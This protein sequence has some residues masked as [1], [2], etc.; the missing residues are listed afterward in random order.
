M[1]IT[2]DAA[3]NTQPSVGHPSS[4]EQNL[5]KRTSQSSL[6]NATSAGQNLNMDTCEPPCS[7]SDQNLTMD[8]SASC[9]SNSE[10]CLNNGANEMDENKPNYISNQHQ[11]I[12]KEV[13]TMDTNIPPSTTHFDKELGNMQNQDS[14]EKKEEIDRAPQQKD[15]YFANKKAGSDTSSD[16]NVPLA[17]LRERKCQ[18]VKRKLI[19]ETGDTD[20]SNEDA[21]YNPD[22]DVYST[23]SEGE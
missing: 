13:K 3:C 17:Q 7:S 10:K 8:T 12:S 1:N 19:K 9:S 11:Q 6:S 23:D 16:G 2:L 14:T 15:N 5:D 22:E 20:A 4:T 18:S 21:L